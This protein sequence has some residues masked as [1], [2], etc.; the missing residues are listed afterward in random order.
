MLVRPVEI[1]DAGRLADIYG[2]YVENT[3]IS[4]E[5]D[6]PT[7]QEMMTRITMCGQRYP[8]FV[9]ETEEGV[10]GYAFASK[11]KDRPSYRYAAELSVYVDKDLRGKGTGSRLLGDLIES[12]KTTPAAILIAG[13]ALPNEPSVRLVEGFGFRKVAVFEKIG[14]KLGKWIDV[15]YWEME[16]KERSSYHPESGGQGAREQR[17]D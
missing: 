10:A 16:I 8:W 11:Y 1:A 9:C 7:H 2:Y 12:L 13:V 6:P 5:I 17:R 14:Y 4:F 3:T 15:G